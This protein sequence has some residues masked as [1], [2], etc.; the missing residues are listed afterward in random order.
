MAYHYPQSVIRRLV[1]AAP[2]LLHTRDETGKTPRE[3]AQ[4]L[5]SFTP[6]K[7]ALEEGGWDEMVSLA[8]F[9]GS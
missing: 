4:S 8:S 7:R 6:F 1:E 9:L 5:K 2:A 3:L